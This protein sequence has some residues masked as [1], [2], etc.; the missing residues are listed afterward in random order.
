M[1][2]A[3]LFIMARNNPNNIPQKIWSYP[4]TGKLFSC[5][6]GCTANG[7]MPYAWVNLESIMLGK[8]NQTRKAVSCMIPFI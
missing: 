6:K 3:A 5:K 7:Y 2:I 4:C 8:R 1:F